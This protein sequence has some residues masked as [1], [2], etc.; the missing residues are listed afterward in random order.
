MLCF[1]LSIYLSTYLSTCIPV[2]SICL[3]SF[4]CRTYYS[5]NHNIHS[6]RNTLSI[7][8]RSLS[9]SLSLTH[10]HVRAHTARTPSLF[11]AFVYHPTRNIK[12]K[13][14]AFTFKTFSPLQIVNSMGNQERYHSSIPSCIRFNNDLDVS[15]SSLLFGTTR[16]NEKKWVKVCVIWLWGRSEREHYR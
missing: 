6:A 15:K 10:T 9:L 8:T 7:H 1:Y 12:R 16:E 13:G 11:F 2:F 14:H 5:L 4:Y 3:P